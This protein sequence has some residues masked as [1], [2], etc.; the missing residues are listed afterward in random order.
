[1]WIL[2]APNINP[3]FLTSL[4]S[5]PVLLERLGARELGVGL[6]AGMMMTPR[7]SISFALWLG[8]RGRPAPGLGGCRACGLRRCRYLEHP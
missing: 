3:I 4:D 6:S 1:M 7:K 2:S 8:A 5:Q